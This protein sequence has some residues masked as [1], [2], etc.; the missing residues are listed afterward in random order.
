MTIIISSIISISL[1]FI[2]FFISA[3]LVLLF[4]PL[5]FIGRSKRDLAFLPGRKR[6]APSGIGRGAPKLV[7]GEQSR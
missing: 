4:K 5:Q 1:V 2:F 7:E 3:T 6:A